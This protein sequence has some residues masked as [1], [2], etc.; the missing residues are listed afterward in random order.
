MNTLDIIAII[1]FAMFVLICT[2]R[3]FLGILS[4]W[5]SFF[6]AM[7]LSKMFGGMVGDM[8]FV[9]LLGS[10]API[11]GTALLFV[12]LFFV[13]RIILGALVKLIT[14]VLHAKA[15]D[16]FFGAI[17]GA[18]GGVAAIF[19]FTFVLDVVVAVVSMFN[20][21]ANIIHMVND[22]SILK[23]FMEFMG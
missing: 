7:I 14:K 8:L 18:V 3:G 10:F 2:V 23:Y 11:V 12:V 13:C 20:V 1:I 17:L 4:K 5:G 19:L 22:T 16:R 15:L 21:D 9:D 6:A